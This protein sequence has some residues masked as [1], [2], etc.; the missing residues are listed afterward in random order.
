MTILTTRAV[1][2]WSGPLWEALSSLFQSFERIVQ[3]FG[4]GHHVPNNRPCLPNVCQS[5]ERMCIVCTW[6]IWNL[7]LRSF[8]HFYWNTVCALKLLTWALWS[9]KI[10]WRLTSVP[11]SHKIWMASR[12]PG[13][14]EHSRAYGGCRSHLETR[15]MVQVWSH[16]AGA[17]CRDPPTLCSNNNTIYI[18][19]S[20]TPSHYNNIVWGLFPPLNSDYLV[21]VLL[22]FYLNA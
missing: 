1:Q 5:W 4:K 16:H 8:R 2:R 13:L 21:R 19:S 6:G 14:L 11:M 10:N 17:S 20:Q 12:C 7:C 9:I 22:P 3:D 15:H 18:F